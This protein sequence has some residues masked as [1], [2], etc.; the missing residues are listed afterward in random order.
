MNVLTSLPIETVSILVLRPSCDIEERMI[1]A[2]KSAEG[3]AESFKKGLHK[4]LS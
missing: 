1:H 3:L 2:L 4:N